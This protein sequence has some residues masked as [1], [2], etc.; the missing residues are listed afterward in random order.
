MVVLEAHRK[1]LE[2]VAVVLFH[3][4]AQQHLQTMAVTA[5][6]RVRAG[7]WCCLTPAAPTVTAEMV[8]MAA[9]LAPLVMVATAVPVMRYTPMAAE[10]AVSLARAGD[11]GS[12]LGDATLLE[13]V[14]RVSVAHEDKEAVER[15]AKEIA[16]LV[17]SGPQGT[18]GYA[19]GRPRPTPVFGYWPCLIVRDRVVVNVALL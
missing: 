17:T 11:V 18:T 15:F 12:V 4:V 10:A 14:L 16:P 8:V 7:S 6:M 2:V 3:P 13:T 19:G 1:F 5:V 9:T